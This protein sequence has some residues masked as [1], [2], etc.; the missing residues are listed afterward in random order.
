MDTIKNAEDIL[1]EK[2]SELVC[3][4]PGATI[5]EALALMNEKELGAI[6]VAREGKVVGMWTER[7]LVREMAA[8]TC[9]VA[10]AKISD[11]MGT[12]LHSAPPDSHVDLLADKMLG[13][14]L[15]YLLI[16]RDGHYMGLLSLGD[17]LRA[18]IH[19]RTEHC[20]EL[21][22]LVDLEYYDQ[23]RWRTKRKAR[24]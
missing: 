18:E 14:R 16:E 1:N 10:T 15:R 21:E 4:E 9:D 8:G 22:H 7:D 13:L 23:W 2:G 6:L 24:P 19:L 3:V 20:K 5:R 11:F 12:T 17:V